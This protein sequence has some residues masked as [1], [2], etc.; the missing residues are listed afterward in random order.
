SKPASTPPF[1]LRTISHCESSKLR[2]TKSSV[3]TYLPAKAVDVF[4]AVFLEPNQALE[5]GSHNTPQPG[6]AESK[7]TTRSRRP[8]S[9][10]QQLAKIMNREKRLT[11]S[12]LF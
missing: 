7:R 6:F 8:D 3:H 5:P 1:C 9:P 2:V 10:I 11:S 12:L 4:L